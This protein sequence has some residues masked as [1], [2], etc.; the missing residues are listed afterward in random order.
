MPRTPQAIAT[1]PP[2]IDA[3]VR[4]LVDGPLV[5]AFLDERAML[6]EKVYPAPEGRWS[7]T[8]PRGAADVRV[9]GWEAV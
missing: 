1:V 8:V 7:V 6:T 9:E 4:V 3:Q 2:G 5:E